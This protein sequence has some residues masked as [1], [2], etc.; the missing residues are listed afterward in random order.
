MDASSDKPPADED[1][2][3]ANRAS[4]VF[5]DG[6]KERGPRRLAYEASF[7]GWGSTLCFLK[8]S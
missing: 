6:P 5:F 3:E 1:A 4:P 8:R 7:L 2:A